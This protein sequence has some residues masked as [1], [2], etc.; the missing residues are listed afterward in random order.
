MVPRAE[1]RTNTA[2]CNPLQTFCIQG[3]QLHFEHTTV[4]CSHLLRETRNK[5]ERA[6]QQTSTN[7][8]K[9]ESKS[10]EPKTEA[11][12]MNRNIVTNLQHHRSKVALNGFITYT[13]F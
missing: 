4:H 2:E 11:K 12:I 3:F 10:G 6:K 13:L 9:T 1:L 8:E 5:Q 7:R